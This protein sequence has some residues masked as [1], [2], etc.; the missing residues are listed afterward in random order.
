MAEGP[1]TFV[2]RK[3]EEGVYGVLQKFG[4]P[5]AGSRGLGPH[6]KPRPPYD[7][8]V[9]PGWLYEM[10]RN[11]ALINN[12]IEEKV[13]QTF[14]R[15]FTEWKRAYIAKCTECKEEFD[16]I[17]PFRDQLG[18][19]GQNLEEEDFDFSKPRP[20][21]DCGEM[22]DFMTPDPEEQDW[23]EDWFQ[24]ANERDHGTEKLEPDVQNSV[25]QTFLE[26]MKEVAWDIQSFDD[27]WM[28]FE[29][30]YWTD[31]EGK[32]DDWELEG[33]YRAPPELMRYSVDEEG[34]FGDDKW[35]CL[36][37][38]ATKERY[39][40][41]KVGTDC[42]SCGNK[43][44]PVYAELMKNPGDSEPIE[45]FIRG[46]FVH[47]SE[48]EP[49]R[50]Y[51]LSPIITLW[52]EARTLEQMDSWYKE[53]YEQRRAPRGAMVVRSSNAESVRSWNIQ[54]ME[55]LKDD[56]QHIP[57][58]IDDTDGKGEPLT[59]QPLLEEP[60]Q[61]QH[62][63]MREWFMDRISAKFGV[64]SIFQSASPRNSGLSQSM[65]IVVSNRS[66]MR[67][68]KVMEDFLDAFVAQL[69]V[70]GWERDIAAIEEE[71]EMAEAQ[72]V[73]KE[74]QN[75]QL[76]LSNGLDAEWTPQDN[77]NIA[78]GKAESEEEGG[79]MA[80]ML[81]GGGDPSG[82]GGPGNPSAQ[83]NAAGA[84][85][86]QGGRPYEPNQLAGEPHTQ[87]E[88]SQDDFVGPDGNKADNTVT[89]G[90]SGWGNATYSGETGGVIDIF[91]HIREQLD[92]EN[93]T[94]RKKQWLQQA[95]RAYDF[96]FKTLGVSADIVEDYAT[97]ES[98]EW[99]DL[100]E[101]YYGKWMQINRPKR[102]TAELYELF[103]GEVR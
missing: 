60:A 29:R 21:P 87:A 84:D 74:L 43:T 36:E 96:N 17:E 34:E 79:G 88:P 68:K 61:M 24:R 20:C 30:S 19:D 28:V 62:M 4:Y 76:A 100:Q 65:E 18:D 59:W 22:V 66:A 3:F 32:V 70:E 46:E 53:A 101:D 44:Y 50:F 86:E 82:G 23:A 97:D 80:E 33:A 39:T 57:T 8:Q 64:T 94:K 52:E 41:Q 63:Q 95:K 93:D 90:D 40:P 6:D 78:P 25:G 71:D 81:G 49:S 27:G 38:R 31:R 73:G 13:N 47:K 35:I 15:G 69:G 7:R 51:G 99:R 75:I 98:K 2:K 26:V 92:D 14:R 102:A 83:Q 56:P 67:L 45:W 55:S 1:F 85:G 9:P 58:F 103:G 10:R 42:E 37:C 72:R 89:T 48:Y 91:E 12:A 54:Q 11:Q 5:S 77:A 16:S